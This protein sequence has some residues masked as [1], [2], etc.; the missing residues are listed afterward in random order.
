VAAPACNTVAS[1]GAPAVPFTARTGMP[2]PSTGGAIRDGLYFATRAEG[3]GNAP[4]TGRRLTLVVTTGAATQLLYAG[5]VLDAAGMTPTSSFRVNATVSSL[6]GAQ[7]GLTTVC[8]SMAASP[9]PSM[10]G[11]T[12]SATELVF[13][14]VNGNDASATTYTRQGCP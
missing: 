2:A 4:Q 1:D 8:S 10:L 5:D 11:Y 12:A 7:I 6:S 14:L 3:Y 13:T 9:L